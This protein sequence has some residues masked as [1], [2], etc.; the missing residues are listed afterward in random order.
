[1][2][3][4]YFFHLHDGTFVADP[5]GTELPDW[6]AAWA[7]AMFWAGEVVRRRGAAFWN[8]E[9][10]RVVVTDA[11]GTALFELRFS[12]HLPIERDI[13]GPPVLETMN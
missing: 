6:R 12:G 4:R 2:I 11:I 1:M 3:A 8:G 9:H 13:L 10:M 5:E 7:H